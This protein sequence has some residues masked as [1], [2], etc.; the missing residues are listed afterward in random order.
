MQ[1]GKILLVR[2]GAARHGRSFLVGPGGR[3]EN[4]ESITR[5]AAREVK[6]ET[7]LDV[8]PDK[9]LFIEDLIS[10]HIRVLKIWFLCR[11]VG[12]QLAK[13]PSAVD[14][15]IEEAGWYSKKDLK[16]EDVY[17]SILVSTD[18]QMFLKDGWEAKYL[19]SEVADADL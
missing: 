8:S 2:Y 4:N 14:E 18:W 12:G 6:E 13:T 3:V 11:L 17:P 19:E 10:P 16:D 9:I 7:G 15:G 5:A 1:E